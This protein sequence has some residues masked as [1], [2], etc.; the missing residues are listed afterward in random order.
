MLAWYFL[1]LA[2]LI[3]SIA[4]GTHTVG[5]LLGMAWGALPLLHPR[6]T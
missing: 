6:R 4:N 3:G 5:L 2:G 1:C